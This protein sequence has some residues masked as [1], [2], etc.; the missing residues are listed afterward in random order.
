VTEEEVGD[1]VE[2]VGEG[3]VLVDGR[4][5]QGA[6]CLRAVDPHR[7]VVELV[8]SRV[9]VDD[10][11]DDLDQGRLAGAVVTDRAVTW[12]AWAE[13]STSVSA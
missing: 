12:P 6:G 5:P 1:H 2:V 13:K 7:P 11:G 9:G 3:E 8:G 4:D 10:P